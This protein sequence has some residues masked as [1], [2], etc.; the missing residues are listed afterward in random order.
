MCRVSLILVTV[1]M[2]CR[3]FMYTSVSHETIFT[4]NVMSQKVSI[5]STNIIVWKMILHTLTMMI[6]ESK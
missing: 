6:S 3:Q 1:G 5:K 4:D 2:W